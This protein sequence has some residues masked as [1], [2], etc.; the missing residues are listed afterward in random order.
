MKGAG[1]RTRRQR[2]RGSQE[3]PREGWAGFEP[4]AAKLV[5]R[6]MNEAVLQMQGDTQVTPNDLV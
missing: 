6:R 3:P 1:E 4:T 2:Q 5:K